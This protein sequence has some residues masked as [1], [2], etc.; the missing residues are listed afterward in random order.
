MGYI[1]H[2]FL[3]P[4]ERS[5]FVTKTEKKQPLIWGV[6]YAYTTILPI[7]ISVLCLTMVPLMIRLAM[8]REFVDVFVWMAEAVF[9]DRLWMV[10]PEIVEPEDLFK[11][12]AIG[13]PAVLFT[14]IVLSIMSWVPEL[15]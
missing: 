14:V 13:V 9:A 12:I 3:S 11:Y 2:F 5:D 8:M 4:A 7:E 1:F 10:L 6:F 15:I